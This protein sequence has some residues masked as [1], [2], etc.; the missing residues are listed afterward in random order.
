MKRL[1]DL[2]RFY[3]LLDRLEQ[4]VGGKRVL[5]NCNGRMDWPQRGVYFF[6]EP[7]EERMHSGKGPRVVRV[8]SHALTSGS[9]STLW[10]RLKQHQG[11]HSSGGGNHRGSIFRLH[12]GTA[13]IR[14]DGWEEACAVSWGK[15]S[16]AER[17]VRQAEVGLERAVSRHIGQ[18]PLLW[19]AVEDEPGPAS[20]RGV[21]ERNAIALL[22][23]YNAPDNPL[24]PPSQS[25]LGQW[26]D[27]EAVRCSG[28]WNV[29]HVT[30]T[31]DP[32]FLD[33]F[34]KLAEAMQR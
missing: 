10:G 22:S 28:L 5:A 32:A 8:G 18:M 14:R 13:L 7:G 12:T 27:R 6:F 30:E 23:N 24:D 21:I 29:N 4:K 17:A 26:A 15:G 19:L 33:L 20:Q 2:G 25:W 16:N 9:Q 31:Y 1:D 3:S 11:R 34:E